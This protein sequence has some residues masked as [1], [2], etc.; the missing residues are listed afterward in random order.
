MKVLN[1]LFNLSVIMLA[2]FVVNYFVH[3]VEVPRWLLMAV[4]LLSAVL[5]FVRT[6]FRIR[7]R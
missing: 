3:V 1:P 7:G 5:F 4:L 6:W 2:L